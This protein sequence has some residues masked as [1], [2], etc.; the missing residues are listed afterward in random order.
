MT[1]LFTVKQMI[2]FSS[3]F[4]NEPDWLTEFGLT[5]TQQVIH[6]YARYG[7]MA[8]STRLHQRK[9]YWHSAPQARQLG[10]PA[11]VSSQAK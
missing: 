1:Q 5:Q 3:L 9:Y 4:Y 2:Q 10:V 6:G 7:A 11:L 8:D